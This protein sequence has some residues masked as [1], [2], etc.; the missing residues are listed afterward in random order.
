[1]SNENREGQKRNR[2]KAIQQEETAKNIKIIVFVILSLIIVGLIGWAVFT[3]VV[4]ETKP[5]ENYSEGIN[6]DGTLA[7]INARDYVNLFDYK[8]MSVKRSDVEVSDEQV[9]SYIDML[10]ESYPSYNTDSSVKIKDGDTI[11]LD[12]VGKVD[13]VPFAGG[14]TEG[15]GTLLKIGSGNYIPGFEEAIIGHN[16]GETFDINVTFPE[17][18]HEELAGK[19]AVFTIT[20]NSVQTKGEFNDQFVKDHLS[21]MADTADGFRDAYKKALQ[22][23]NIYAYVSD[24]IEKNTNVKNYPKSYLKIVKGQFRATDEKAYEQAKASMGGTTPYTFENY[25]GLS[26]K[27]YEA[28]ITAK[29]MENLDTILMM[30]AIYEDAG[31]EP[32]T[33]EEV[34]EFM[35]ELGIGSEYYSMYEEDYGKGYLYQ[36]GLSYKVLKYLSENVQIVD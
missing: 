18:Y 26:K 13:G 1:M 10:L 11:N 20:I 28:S 9:D 34:N 2:L 6:D 32:V 25:T 4:I 29:A 21:Y 5:V 33:Q 12:Y 30:Q 7:G 22:E 36:A 19:D 31:L 23:Q 16:V 15:Q 24:T 27:E 14:S 3:S 35:D 8:N 17:E